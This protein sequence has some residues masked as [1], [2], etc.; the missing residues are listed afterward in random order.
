MCSAESFA[1]GRVF[2][3][4]HGGGRGEGIDALNLGG[5]LGIDGRGRQ[6]RDTCCAYMRAVAV[7]GPIPGRG[8]A[9]RC[10]RANERVDYLTTAPQFTFQPATHKKNKQKI[11]E[12]CNE[13]RTNA[14]TSN[15]SPWT[16]SCLVS[17]PP[18]PV[19]PG[20]DVPTIQAETKV[21]SVP[22]PCF[23][24]TRRRRGQCTHTECESESNA[25]ARRVSSPGHPNI[26]LLVDCLVAAR[27]NVSRPCS[28]VDG[29]RIVHLG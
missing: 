21:V 29:G 5:E 13:R 27:V 9:S 18:S 7:T 6:T 23:F 2:E 24:L 1:K 14:P 22:P 12:N 8:K 20:L 3:A 26:L 10:E 11:T 17:N 16:P 15:Q 4:G 19:S 28:V 25:T